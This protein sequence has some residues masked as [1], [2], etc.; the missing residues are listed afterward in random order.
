MAILGTPGERVAKLGRSKVTY[1]FLVV[2]YC[3]I[4]L[5]S[6]SPFWTSKSKNELVFSGEQQQIIIDPIKE[7]ETSVRETTRILYA[8]SPHLDAWLDTPLPKI[9]MYDNLEE[10]WSNL[11]NIS[12]GAEERFTITK[13]GENYTGC[14]WYPHICD[15][16]HTGPMNSKVSKFLQ[17]KT[18]FM[19]DVAFLKWFENYPY[20]TWNVSEADLLVV[21]YPH[22]SHCLSRFDFSRNNGEYMNPEIADHVHSR[23]EYLQQYPERHVYLHGA[24][25]GT[26]GVLVRSFDIRNKVTISYGAGNPCYNRFHE[27]CGHLIQPMV[28]VRTAF[29]PPAIQEKLSEDWFVYRN[30]THAVG[31]RMGVTAQMKLRWKMAANLTEYVP[32]TIGGLPTSVT[33][34]TRSTVTSNSSGLSLSELYQSSV[35]CLIL[36][37][38]EPWQKRIF[39]VMLEGCIPL[40][41]NWVP[42]NE[43][44]TNISTWWQWSGRPSN[45]VVY[46][47]HRGW[48]FGDNDAG[49]DWMD[50][51]LPFD[52]FHPDVSLALAVEQA[53]LNVE[54]IYRLR[55][56][57]MKCVQL[58][59]YGL[60][61]NMYRYADGFTA[62]LVALRHYVYS[63]DGKLPGAVSNRTFGASP[64][65]PAIGDKR[66]LRESDERR[67]G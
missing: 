66:S 51:V 33:F 59:S 65:R 42:S 24:G 30:R 49:I 64:K 18:N 39:D 48:F 52:G 16:K 7:F 55:R 57:I 12:A 19:V 2:A 41:P 9:Y 62:G 21:P 53:M 38:D 67:Y 13:M 31:G 6:F 32:K 58:F 44:S 3:A 37:G 40:V 45:R 36:P 61:E 63:L 25:W 4:M 35:F 60:D 50:L 46:P 8:N 1:V 22:R 29:Q 20:R 5:F 43:P 28:D 47:W 27:P 56:N 14:G 26:G 34:T 10:S 23:L 54:E 11:E 15:K 17:Y